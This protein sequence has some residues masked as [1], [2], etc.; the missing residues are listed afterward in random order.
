MAP[1]RR[2]TI[3]SDS[4]DE[5]PRSTQRKR[6]RTSV[7]D[8]E[9]EVQPVD[10]AI[11]QEQELQFEREH[12]E[13][14][15]QRVQERADDVKK[16]KVI[17][18]VAAMGIIERVEML[19]FMCHAYL[20]FNFGPQINFIIG[21]NG[22]G[23]S[24]VLTAI[25]I[26]MGGKA[27]VTGRGSGLKSFIKEGKQAS[28]VTITLKN[29]GDE[30][31]KHDL[32]GDSI[33]ITRKF[34]FKGSSTYKIKSKDGVL[35]SNKKEELSAI[36][37]HMNIQVDNPMN[38]LTQDSAR[39]FLSASHPSEKYQFFLKGTQLSQLSDEYEICFANVRQTSK[40]L[41]QK[42]KVLPDLRSAAQ[43]A[44]DRFKEAEKAVELQKKIDKLKNELVWA[45]VKEK[46][47]D[48][49]SKLSNL[50]KARARLP[51]VE[52]SIR[53]A[54]ERFEDCNER[55]SRMEEEHR[56]IGT[57]DHI[58]AQRD[59]LKK[60][61]HILNQEVQELAGDQKDI[62]SRI[63]TERANIKNVELQI[64]AET[65][66]MA[67]H[68][69]ERRERA[70]AKLEE[71]KAAVENAEARLK[72]LEAQM[73]EKAQAAN[74]VRSE[75][76]EFRAAFEAA[77]REMEE[78][79]NQIKVARDSEKNA[80]APYG[81]NMESVI[82]DVQKTRWHGKE[83]LGPLGR[84]V[85]LKDPKWADVLRVNLSGSMVSWAITDARDRG[86]LKAL[87]ERYGNR[88]APIII[89]A[90]DVFDYSRGEPPQEYL[91]PLRVLAFSNEW[92]T[93]LFINQRSIESIVL[94]RTRAEGDD[95]CGR[96]G[97]NCHAWCG[98]DS[99]ELYHVYGYSDGGKQS[100]PM[101]FPSG[102][103]LQMFVTR[104][105][106]ANLEFWNQKFG[107]AQKDYSENK[108]KA[109]DRSNLAR[110]LMN[111]SREAK[112]GARRAHQALIGAK[113]EVSRLQI[114]A[115]EELPAGLAGLQELKKGHED[116]IES[117]KTQFA[118]IV[119]KKAEVERKLEPLNAESDK[120]KAEMDDFDARRE[121]H[122]NLIEG[123]VEE[124]VKATS[125]IEHWKKKKAEEEA[126]IKDAEQAAETTEAELVDWTKTARE[127]APTEFKEPRPSADVNRKLESAKGALKKQ[128]SKQ[129]ASVEEITAELTRAK[130]AYDTA[131]T[132][133]KTMY[134]LNKELSDAVNARLSRWHDFRRHIALRC[135]VFFQFNLAH[136]GY[137]GKVLFDHTAQT[138]QLRV[139][140]E[141]MAATQVRAKDK[142]PK[143]LS[144][145]EKSFSTICL[146]LA[147]WESIG[148]PIRCLDE[149]DVFMDAVNRRISMKMM[150]D[151]AK[152]SDGKQ[153]IL[154]T[155]QDMQNVSITDAVRVHRMIDPER[156]QGILQFGS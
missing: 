150:I 146:L 74:D 65:K 128:E 137:F 29:R 47:D 105:T 15:M 92:V 95:V 141:E 117:M 46:R 130:K 27:A 81:N 51:K 45:H 16:H 7:E 67:T 138:L 100:K 153:Y 121:K 21:H 50:G 126:T 13:A 107:A 86:P 24:A 152:A 109:E 135:K 49:K 38:V 76:N 25:T 28:E 151:T 90:V 32:Y 2:V 4:E 116:S 145:G 61:I 125:D 133:I 147:L 103:Q 63:K 93:R 71:A 80:L 122:S 17:G 26:A 97:G 30:A 72:S 79:E 8:T 124:R 144:G 36:C 148:C 10:N 115:N 22:S 102:N 104:D 69:N 60:K 41:Q 113:N 31:F 70:R 9:A 35:I 129:G 68:T 59:E 48:L 108:A 96:L 142:D 23:K 3:Q 139:Q 98:T 91:T 149:F 136:R 111:E 120:L 123:V 127:M 83:P 66:R 85:K 99:R 55:I 112:D 14:F 114:E 119:E 56:S 94:A 12:E 156:N 52:E 54:E 154:I 33:V 131:V 11:D 6:Q 77:K 39:Q 5:A 64:D 101:P 44:E 43:A 75:E 40:I 110:K 34:D 18:G 118:A 62:N 1:K 19:D 58:R 82:R 42:G 88:N 106:R 87:L 53:E 155:P 134:A 140:T 20:K 73:E 57:V 89:S 84:Y 143:A 37:D 78:C 132:E